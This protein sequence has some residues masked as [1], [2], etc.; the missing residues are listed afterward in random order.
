M[1]GSEKTTYHVTR[2]VWYAFGVIEAIL[3][4][5]LIL[6][7]LAANSAAAFTQLVYATSGIFL[8]PFQF[9]FGAPS[10]GGS[11][12]ELS[13][14]LAIIVYW[15]IAWGIVKLILMNRPVS[16]VEARSSLE[17]QDNA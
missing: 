17:R 14:I 11:V 12:L 6:K 7:F 13:T 15:M 2:V 10:A 4:L 3:V 8:A 16:E 1:N 5:R 9:V